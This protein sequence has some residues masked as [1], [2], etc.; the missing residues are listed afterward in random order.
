MIRPANPASPKQ[1]KHAVNH[2]MGKHSDKKSGGDLQTDSH[3]SE[4]TQTGRGGGAAGR[5]AG[6]GQ[7]RA[8]RRA[9]AR[10]AR[11]N[12]GWEGKQSKLLTT[13]T[14]MQYKN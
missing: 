6:G 5:A 14:A 13:Q 10:Q 11:G 2:D 12:R 8:G 1:R 7:A 3:R 9:G 4:Y